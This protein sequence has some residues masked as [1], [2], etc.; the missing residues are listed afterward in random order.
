[1]NRIMIDLIY[2]PLSY[3]TI[4]NNKWEKLITLFKLDINMFNFIY[5]LNYFD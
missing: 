5:N 4:S 3:R 1:M 2:C